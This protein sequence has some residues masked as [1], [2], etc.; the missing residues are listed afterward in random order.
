MPVE[1]RLQ[2]NETQHLDPSLAHPR[3]T[4]IMYTHITEKDSGDSNRRRGQARR[5]NSSSRGG[6]AAAAAGR[7]WTSGRRRRRR[8]ARWGCS[9][10]RGA[11][12]LSPCS[13]SRPGEW[14]S[15]AE[16]ACT[17]ALLQKHAW[18]CPCYSSWRLG[19]LSSGSTAVLRTAVPWTLQASR[20]L[21]RN[22]ILY[23][24]RYCQWELKI[25]RVE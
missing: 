18:K 14:Y 2:I 16:E 21:I 6:A 25:F 20:T 4:P 8:P 24:G 11:G 23:L 22:W 5:A 12:T 3:T 10:R 9:R 15:A 7:R 19:S 13:R 1:Y 17:L